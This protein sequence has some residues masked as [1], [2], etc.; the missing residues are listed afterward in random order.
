MDPLLKRRSQVQ[1]SI[2]EILNQQWDPL[3]V[4]DAGITDE[5]DSL[6]G[7]IYDLLQKEGSQE[8]ISGVLEEF[9]R[10]VESPCDLQVRTQ[11]V[12]SLLHLV[13]K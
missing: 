13:G 7:L 10:Q 9:E 5:Y 12:A 1:S 6:I 11:V 3:D 4:H 8:Q 2:R